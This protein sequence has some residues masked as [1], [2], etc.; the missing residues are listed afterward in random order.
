MKKNLWSMVLALALCLSLTAGCTANPP[1]TGGENTAPVPTGTEHTGT[2]DGEHPAAAPWDRD[3]GEHWQTGPDGEPVNAAPHSLNEENFC[4][5]CGSEVLQH[6]GLSDVSDYNG[7]GDLIRATRYAADGA[8]L[9]EGYYEYAEGE[10]GAVYLAVVT[11]LYEDGA[12]CLS[13][14]DPQGE[15]ISWFRY[16]K[17]GTVLSEVHYEYTQN[18]DGAPLMTRMSNLYPDGSEYVSEYNEYG[19]QTAWLVYAADGTLQSEKRTQ[20][21]HD[22]EGHRLSETV[23]VDGR[24]AREVRYLNY[25]D[26]SGWW[27]REQRVTDYY[28]DGSKLVTE[29]NES[30]GIHSAVTYDADGNVLSFG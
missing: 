25:T 17:D 24:L 9:S 10:D 13:E 28:E 16:D 4:T 6:N 29:Y 8:V 30:G 15:L 5:V 7:A 12:R 18:D 22:A 1:D 14:Y 27:T 20:W 23:W 3:A 11:D 21:E 19:E 26:G 2:P